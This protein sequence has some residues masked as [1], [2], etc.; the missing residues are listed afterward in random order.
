MDK[1][2]EIQRAQQR[3][4]AGWCSWILWLAKDA[5]KQQQPVAWGGPDITCLP[6]HNHDESLASTRDRSHCQ[7]MTGNGKRRRDNALFF[8]FF[9]LSRHHLAFHLSLPTSPALHC[10]FSSPFFF[11]SSIS[12]PS[13]SCFS[14][15]VYRCPPSLSTSRG[16][17]NKKREQAGD[18]INRWML[19]VKLKNTD[20]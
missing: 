4:G 13:L 15:L 7:T 20:A 12:F 9:P 14:S 3:H 2:G 16:A 1:R 5:Q 8:P 10:F 18:L 19:E 17:G 11:V 6:P